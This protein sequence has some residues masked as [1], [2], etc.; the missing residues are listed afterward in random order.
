MGDLEKLAGVTKSKA[1]LINE[2]F[3]RSF[4]RQLRSIPLT[5]C[6]AASCA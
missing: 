3:G 5:L 1:D 2:R 4:H 6:V